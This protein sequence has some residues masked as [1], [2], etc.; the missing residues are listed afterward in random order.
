MQRWDP[1]L[2]DELQTRFLDRDEVW[3][4][5]R[6]RRDVV[7]QAVGRHKRL[8]EILGEARALQALDDWEP[9][10][11][12]RRSSGLAHRPPNPEAREP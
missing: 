7:L 11:R 9:T 1:A 10:R 4:L 8:R 3:E 6:Y 2:S 12:P 5:Q